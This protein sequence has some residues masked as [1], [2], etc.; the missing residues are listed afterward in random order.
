MADDSMTLGHL[1]YLSLSAAV[2][3]WSA[4]SILSSLENGMEEQPL[5]LEGR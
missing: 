2:W 1:H 4:K 5:L 3:L